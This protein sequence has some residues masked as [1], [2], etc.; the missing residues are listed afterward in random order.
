MHEE[1]SQVRRGA[2]R[3]RVGPNLYRRLTSAGERFDVAFRDTDGR[4]R[5]KVLEARTLRAAEREARRV[6]ARRDTGDR[7]TPANITL[8]AFVADEYEPHI[9]ALAAAGRKAEQG[10][11][12]EK[13]MLRLY[14]L[15]ALGDLRL[16]AISGGDVA[17]LL[18]SMRGRRDK[19]G[20]PAPLSEASLH[21][22]C[23]VLR[24]IFRLARARKVITR[25]PLDEL[26]E[27][28]R[29]RRSTAKI[30]RRLDEGELALLVAHAADDTYRTAIA[31]LAY[32]GCR[33]SEACGLHWRDV[34]LVDSEV[35]VAGQLS[36]A[37]R[38][39]RAR[40]IPRKGNAPPYTALVF[41]A[42]ADALTAHLRR[43]LVAGRGRE[44]DFVLSTVTGRPLYQ[45]NVGHALAAASEAAGLGRVAPHDL[46]RSFCSLAARRGVDPVQAARMAGMSV[47]VFLR[48]YA[49]EYG[50][51]HREEARARL[52][53]HG[54]GASVSGAVSGE[55][56]SD[57][58]LYGET[59]A[60]A[61]A[62]SVG[63]GRFE[64]PTSSPPGAEDAEQGETP[65]DES[66]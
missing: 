52:L 16:G 62:S 48:H 23:T 15:P 9:D 39:E 3:E 47:E 64:L 26:D 63:A 4:L 60:V 19:D 54:F 12:L 33:I 28:E 66:A 24:S 45:R 8:R 22:A 36:R 55:A 21:N 53:A 41:P 32:T 25:S 5:F 7:V 18:R 43:E 10:V 35:T 37:T 6:L 38:T 49:D 27:S 51:A 30:G 65:E 17:G 58:P 13:D 40:I 2:P 1:S 46:R 29:P 56:V 61:G 31:I 59:P 50:R 57:E 34:D 11:R 44:D 14:V 20:Q 42:L